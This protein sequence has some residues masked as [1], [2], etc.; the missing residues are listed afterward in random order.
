MHSSDNSKQYCLLD[1]DHGALW[2]LLMLR[3]IST[4][5]YL[6]TYLIPVQWRSGSSQNNVG[7]LY[8]FKQGI[9]RHQTPHRY[10]N[11]AI[12]PSTAKRDVIHKT[13]S[14]QRIA[15]PPEEDQA[16]T[17]GCVQNF[18]E[19][20]SSISRDKLADRETDRQTG[21]SQYSA[22]LP[23]PSNYR[24]GQKNRTVFWQFVTPVYVDIE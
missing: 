3:V 5:T 4:L 20:R 21:W 23:G 7:A 10:R 17:Q 18:R 2:L 11:I 6:L 13:G 1:R 12:R 9:Y 24:V 19:D 22:P 8:N 16:T 14:T 15:T